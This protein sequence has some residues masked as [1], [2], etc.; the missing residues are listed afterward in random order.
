[1]AREGQDDGTPV[2]TGLPADRRLGSAQ[3]GNVAA[4][5]RVDG[6]GRSSQPMNSMRVVCP[7]SWRWIDGIA[8]CSQV[9]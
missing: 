8:N 4:L 9:A 6:G 5:G 2:T 1:M 3:N 7:T